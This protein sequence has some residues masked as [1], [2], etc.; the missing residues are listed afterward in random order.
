MS[1]RRRDCYLG[2]LSGSYCVSGGLVEVRKY[3]RGVRVV[4]VVV[5]ID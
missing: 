2:A 3:E 4:C 5:L 1:P